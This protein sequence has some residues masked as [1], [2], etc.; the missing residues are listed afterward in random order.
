MIAVAICWHAWSYFVCFLLV[1]TMTMLEFYRLVA[2]SGVTPRKYI[3]VLG[4]ISLY[5]LTFLY[6]ANHLAS[7]YFYILCPVIAFV[8]IA[9]LY[10]KHA[11]PFTNI[12]Y[13][14]LGIVYVSS[15]FALLHVAAF[16]EGTYRYEM[17]IGILC[18]LWTY[19]T[20]AYLV[21]SGMGKWRLFRRISPQKSWEGT[22]GGAVLAL[23]A[24]H[25]V[26]NHWG[27][28]DA[29]T[30]LGVGFIIVVAGTYGDLA[31]SM[32]KRSLNIKDSGTIIPGHGGMLDRFDSFL[33]AI[34]HVV[35]FIKLCQ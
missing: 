16:T 14:L 13:T 11:A 18:I 15:P 29:N 2:L 6:A 26:A 31:A 25:L 34:T 22:L 27:I 3:G 4:G 21:G 33:F 1:V 17:V 23:I 12:A 32:L 28:L 30:W 9:E 5:T 35:V 20:S 24:S 10:Y 19:D 7:H 8:F